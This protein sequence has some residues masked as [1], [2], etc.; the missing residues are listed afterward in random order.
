M[1]IVNT[2]AVVDARSAR[3]GKDGAL[4]NGKGQMLA[5]VD[6]FSSKVNV[7]T[8]EYKPVGVLNAQNIVNGTAV[9][10]TFSQYVVEDDT[11][12]QEFMKFMDT[13][14]VPE[15]N[16]TG[17]LKGD[18]GSEERIVYRNCVPNGD[19]DLQNV[20]PGELVKRSW[21]FQCNATPNLQK[22]LRK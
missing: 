3:A 7:S 5:T 14:V 1:P 9:T 12:I 2:Q 10:L 18:N 20:T 4:Y 22:K 8:T 21:T 15:W 6:T 19:I 17:V 11:L 16:F 13:G